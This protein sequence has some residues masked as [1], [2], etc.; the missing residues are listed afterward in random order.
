MAFL[1]FVLQYKCILKV[2]FLKVIFIIEINHSVNTNNFLSN[3]ISIIY[4]TMTH[5]SCYELDYINYENLY[6]IF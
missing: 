4:I 2:T 5:Y 6:F 3:I 1:C